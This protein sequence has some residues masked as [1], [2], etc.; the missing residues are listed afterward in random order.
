MGGPSPFWCIGD[1]RGGN[2]REKGGYFDSDAVAVVPAEV[3]VVV[4][5]AAGWSVY[6][7][8]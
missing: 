2:E 3:E 7:C 1:E 5:A 8:D 4:V 6:A